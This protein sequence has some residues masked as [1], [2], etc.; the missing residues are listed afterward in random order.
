M[1]EPTTQAQP[2]AEA[3]EKLPEADATSLFFESM[4]AA[5]GVETV[6]GD[7]ITIGEK[8]IIPVAETGLGGGVGGAR[9]ER[10][11]G[12]QRR[13]LR[14]P[15]MSSG[16]GGGANTRPVAAIIVGP[17]GVRVQPIFDLTKIALAGMA[18]SLTL[19]RGITEFVKAMRK[20]R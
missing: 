18:S 7:P 16:G 11:E 4:A 1:N 9:F 3:E 19:W 6:F 17:E 15:Y 12:E 2:V 10:C 13:E 5:V 14:F 20:R 8:V